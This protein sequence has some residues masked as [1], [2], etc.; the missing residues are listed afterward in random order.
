MAHAKKTSNPNDA[1]SQKQYET[2]RKNR[3][4]QTTAAHRLHKEANVPLGPCG[5]PEIQ[6]FQQHLT[7]YQILVYSAEMQNKRI[8]TGHKKPGMLMNI[9]VFT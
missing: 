2:I 6:L 3:L 9:P 5:V 7:D 8:F 1:E 4:P